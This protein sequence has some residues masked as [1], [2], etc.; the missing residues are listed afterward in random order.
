MLKRTPSFSALTSWHPNLDGLPR[1]CMMA[2]AHL[3]VGYCR[4]S[5]DGPK[6]KLSPHQRREALERL[7]A[8]Q[9]QAEIGRSYGVDA[10]TIGR[11]LRR[12]EE[13][14]GVIHHLPVPVAATFLRSTRRA[15]R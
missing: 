1:P 3:I 15:V 10:T 7:R 12:E 13:R 11:L 4:V 6:F 14:E 9:T 8:G 2:T 5:T